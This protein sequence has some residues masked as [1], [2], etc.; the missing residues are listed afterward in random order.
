MCFKVVRSQR[1]R[2]L[3][4]M[5]KQTWQPGSP[6]TLSPNLLQGPSGCGIPS[7][8]P[9]T[10][11]AQGLYVLPPW[12]W[13]LS[14]LISWPRLLLLVSSFSLLP[15]PFSSRGPS[16]SGC[17]HSGFSQ[18]SLPLAMLSCLFTISFLL[19][20]VDIPGSSHVFSFISFFIQKSYIKENKT[21]I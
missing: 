13:L 9:G 3:D 6:G 4:I 16:Q 14:R 15:C 18:R 8:L 17:V 21:S 1:L 12:F 11:P 5:S 20:I 10:Y 19:G 7:P 2:C